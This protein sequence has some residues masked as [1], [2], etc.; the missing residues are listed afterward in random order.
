MEL[1]SQLGPQSRQIHPSIQTKSKE[2]ERGIQ[3]HILHHRGYQWVTIEWNI[4][5]LESTQ[6]HQ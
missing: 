5:D 6:L 4:I 1:G 2:P 3:I